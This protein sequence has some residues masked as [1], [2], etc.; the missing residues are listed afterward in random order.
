MSVYPDSAGY[1]TGGVGHKLTAAEQ[2]QYTLGQT[3]PQGIIETWLHRDVATAEQAV[4]DLV[5]A[6]LTQSQFDAL[7][8]FVFNIGRPRFS[9]ST[10]LQR[11]NSGDYGAV[12]NQLRRWVYVNGERNHGL[13]RRRELE[14]ERWLA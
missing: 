6:P 10:L 4:N 8:V 5:T 7:V 3:I 9:T 14:V 2:S 12:P 1:W 13:A 11:L